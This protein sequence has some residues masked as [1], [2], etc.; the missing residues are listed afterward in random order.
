[1]KPENFIN[2]DWWFLPQLKAMLV[3][4]MQNDNFT[5]RYRTSK[6]YRDRNRYLHW[7][8]IS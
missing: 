4:A 6:W 7:T 1:L 8:S 2:L 5:L 3:V